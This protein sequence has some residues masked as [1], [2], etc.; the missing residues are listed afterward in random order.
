MIEKVRNIAKKHV[1][2]VINIRKHLHAN[3]EL[4]FKEYE[5][6]KYI[7]SILRK[8]DIPF[9]TGHVETGIIATIQGENPDSKEI[10]L[11]ADLDALPITED[12][13]TEYKSKNEGVNLFALLII[14]HGK[15][16]K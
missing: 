8:H 15:Y 9:T 2:E 14:Q 11:R 7:Q 5:T 16:F 12:N 4:S 3:P 13:N 1:L 10:L 6:S